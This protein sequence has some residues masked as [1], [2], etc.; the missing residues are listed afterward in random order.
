MPADPPS[1]VAGGGGIEKDSAPRADE[2][3]VVS[4]A[5]APGSRCPLLMG[6]NNDGGREGRRSDKD[7]GDP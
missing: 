7:D 6:A 2:M 1:T 5:I 3:L 4:G